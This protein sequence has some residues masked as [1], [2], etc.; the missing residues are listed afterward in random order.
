MININVSDRCWQ[1]NVL[2]TTC[3]WLYVTNIDVA[4]TMP[5]DI[6]LL[7]D[8]IQKSKINSSPKNFEVTDRDVQTE[9]RNEK[10]K[11]AKMIGKI[12]ISRSPIE[13]KD[14]FYPEKGFPPAYSSPDSNSNFKV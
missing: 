3:H 11:N 10:F 14:E 6:Q 5:L 9:L 2:M 13:Q 1:Q 8:E 7:F 4:W 12:R